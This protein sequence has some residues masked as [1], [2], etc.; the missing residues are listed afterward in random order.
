[1]ALVPN[2]AGTS[3][4]LNSKE[5]TAASHAA[6]LEVNLAGVPF[7]R[8]L[9][10]SPVGTALQ[11][12]IALL[13]G[14]AGTT[15]AS[16]TNPYLVRIE[17]GLYDLGSQTLKQP[18][19]VDIEGSGTGVTK[20]IAAVAPAVNIAA[21]S[22][23]R[24]VSVESTQGMAILVLGRLL[25]VSARASGGSSNTAIEGLGSES[26]METSAVAFGPGTVNR[27]ITISG[28]TSLTNVI[29]DSS[30]STSTGRAIDIAGTGT[31]R[32][33]T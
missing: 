17:P 32:L 28:N 3:I 19:F 9:V 1:M 31:P 22:E 6:R 24:H 26:M 14:V 10:V 27:A 15:G 12:G 25:H 2:A 20:I 21:G 13:A 4:D 5:N 29:A 33:L 16:A 30:G 8:T 23:L 18:A 7:T 11:N